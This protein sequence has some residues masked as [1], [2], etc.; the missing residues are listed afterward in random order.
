[1]YNGNKTLYIGTKSI[2]EWLA[3]YRS[4]LRVSTRALP[5]PQLFETQPFRKL[6]PVA[7]KN[8]FPTKQNKKYALKSVY[9]SG[10]HFCDIFYGWGVKYPYLLVINATTRYLYAEPINDKSGDDFIRAINNIVTLIGQHGLSPIRVLRADGEKGFKAKAGEL[11]QRFNIQFQSVYHR[12]QAEYPNFM[13][14][15]NDPKFGQSLNHTALSVIDRVCRTLR[16][17]AFNVGTGAIDPDSMAKLVT[18]YNSTEHKTL[19]NIMGFPVTPLIANSDS[20]L[21]DEIRRRLLIHNYEITQQQ[22]YDDIKVD[23]TVVVYNEYVDL[24]KKRRMICGNKLYKVVY[25]GIS[26]WRSPES[27]DYETIH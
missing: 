25:I 18:I 12:I 19:S 26:S 5:P 7:I 6:Q 16:D 20:Q 14:P 3:I 4:K 8:S 27:K 24:P 10:I 13:N 21:E 22:G 9:S 2:D 15:E 1:L 11:R 23:D 17:A